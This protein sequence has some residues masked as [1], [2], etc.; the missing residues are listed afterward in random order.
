MLF[1][2]VLLDTVNNYYSGVSI[3]PYV[4][5]SR[6]KEKE[7]IESIKYQAPKSFSAQNRAVTKDDYITLINQNSMGIAFDAVNV[8]GGEENDPPIYGQVFICLKP[9]NAYSI[10]QTQK[11]ELITKVLRP[12]SVVTVEPKII[13]PDYTFISL[14]VDVRYNPKLT[15]LTSTEI[16]DLKIGRAHV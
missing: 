10:T 6:G 5:A 14:D 11:D 12:I 16:S 7:S 3:Y 2:S 9:K 1:R 8:W 13:D 15:N 4:P